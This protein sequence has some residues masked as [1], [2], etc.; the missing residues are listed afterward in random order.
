MGKGKRTYVLLSGEH[1]AISK[2]KRGK[3]K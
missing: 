1:I 3:G 2:I